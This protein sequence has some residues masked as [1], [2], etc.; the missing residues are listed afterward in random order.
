MTIGLIGAMEVEIELYLKAMTDVEESKGAGMS[1][2]RGKYLE[3]DLVLCQSGVG[4]VNAAI[5][6]QMLIDRYGVDQ[7]IFTGV[8]GALD[9]S[10]RVGDVV[11]SVDCLQH[12]FDVT[13][14]GYQ[15]GQIPGVAT[16]FEADSALVE[17]AVKAS[18]K[19]TDW[20][21]IKGRVLSG[22]TF[23]ADREYVKKLHSELKG[24]C[25]EMEGADVAQV[26]TMNKIPFVII[27]SMSDKADGSAHTSYREF[28]FLA[29]Q[30]SYEI[31]TRMIGAL[32]A[33]SPQVHK[34]TSPQAQ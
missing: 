6:T 30:R 14:L 10:L 31:V 26:C 21:T 34:S 3:Q 1:F 32:G 9:P 8:A 11:I 29:A 20:Q 27:R 24:T 19:T 22:D 13:A 16:T 28:K 5:C 12:D 25:A 2:W 23:V 18:E 15:W 33:D 4:K 7:V 17:L